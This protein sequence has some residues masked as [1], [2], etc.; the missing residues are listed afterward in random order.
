MN[1][2]LVHLPDSD[3]F[4]RMED[5]R[6]WLDTHR[7]EPSSFRQQRSDVLEISFRW[8]IEAEAFAA[9]LSDASSR[10]AGRRPATFRRPATLCGQTLL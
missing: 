2:V 8:R 5:M 4:A 6:G 7:C 3:L 9:Q 1:T 10:M